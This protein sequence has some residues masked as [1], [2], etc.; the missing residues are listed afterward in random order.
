MLVRLEIENF[1][2]IRD[3]Q[4]LDLRLPLSTPPDPRFRCAI[5]ERKIRVPSVCMFFGANAS[6]KTTALR[7][8]A[9]VLDFATDSF[10]DYA[11]GEDVLS[12]PFWT[13]EHMDK[14]TSVAVEFSPAALLRAASPDQYH[15]LYRYELK[16]IREGNRR[17][18][19]AEFLGFSN[20]NRR[21]TALF[22]RQRVG[23][24]YNIRAHPS[25]ELSESDPRRQVRDNVSLVSSLLQFNHPPSVSLRNMLKYGTHQNIFF[26][27]FINEEKNVNEL[28]KSNKKMLD[29]LN[30]R[31]RNIDL[32]IER[33]EIM[34][35]DGVPAPFFFHTGLSYP[36]SLH[37]QSD[38]TKNFYL[39]FIDLTL[40]LRLG[41]VAIMDELDSDL[42]PHLMEEIVR[43]FQSE[44]ENPW[45]A[46]LVMACHNASV[47]SELEKEEVWLAEKDAAGATTYKWLAK[48]PALRRGA[49]LYGKYLAGSLGAVPHFG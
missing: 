41:A 15:A 7:A 40:A 44:T 2:S 22:T 45:G 35:V 48:F 47:L 26:H 19:G 42:H 31:I 30:R 21:F 13:D 17:I 16:I 24:A 11:T 4:V 9:F 38:G 10:D 49:N 23:E 5:A 43:W 36:L 20:G 32:G 8:L 34:D 27:K 14:P 39:S 12:L 37:Y 18:V 1:F 29:D 25:F 28:L 46:Q 3:R 33:V 6:G